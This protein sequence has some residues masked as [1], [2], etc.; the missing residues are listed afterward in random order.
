[1]YNVSIKKNGW[2]GPFDRTLKRIKT[3][4]SQEENKFK[5]EE[6]L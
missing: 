5:A 2:K 1:M 4:N 3:L 6:K